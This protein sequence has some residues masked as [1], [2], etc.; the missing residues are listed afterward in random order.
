MAWKE[1][2]DEIADRIVLDVG[3]VQQHARLP[4]RSRFPFQELDARGRP[5]LLKSHGEGGH[6]ILTYV[7][8]AMSFVLESVSWLQARSQLRADAARVDRTMRDQLWNTTD[9]AATKRSTAAA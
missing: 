2:N 7:V 4:A 9:P 3:S 5:Q 6:F 8:L 1:K